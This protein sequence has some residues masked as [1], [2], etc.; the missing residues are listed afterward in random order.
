[1][2]ALVA[3]AIIVTTVAASA[4]V[5]HTGTRGDVHRWFLHYGLTYGPKRWETYPAGF[6][7]IEECV[8]FVAEAPWSRGEHCDGS[9]F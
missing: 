5:V 1:M 7:N 6:D 3:V 2:R 8:Q 4:T 9:R